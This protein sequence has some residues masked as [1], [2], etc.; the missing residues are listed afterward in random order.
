MPV[1]Q[2]A[3]QVIGVLAVL[4]ATAVLVLAGAAELQSSPAPPRARSAQAPAAALAASERQRADHDAAVGRVEFAGY[5]VLG[6]ALLML[7]AALSGGAPAPLTSVTGS[8]L[9]LAVVQL[10]LFEL[11]GQSVAISALHVVIAAVLLGAAV[12]AAVRHVLLPAPWAT[13]YARDA[14]MPV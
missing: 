12:R 1:P 5:T 4:A 10:L 8:V 6:L 9:A 3:H 11:R 7:L 14:V 2:L 13:Q